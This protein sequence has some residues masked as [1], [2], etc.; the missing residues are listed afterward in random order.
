MLAIV[1]VL[2]DAR[3]LQEGWGRHAESETC[4]HRCWGLPGVLRRVLA[5]AGAQFSLSVS[6]NKHRCGAPFGRPFESQKRVS[7]YR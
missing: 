2:F 6:A 4:F 1:G 7:I 5:A 3:R